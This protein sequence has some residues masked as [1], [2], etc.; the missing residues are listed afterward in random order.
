MGALGLS[1]VIDALAAAKA[2]QFIILG[3]TGA[4]YA[5]F[6][7]DLVL[8]GRYLWKTSSRTWKAF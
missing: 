3:L 1:V 6:A 8:F 2:K 7:A 5:L 4:E